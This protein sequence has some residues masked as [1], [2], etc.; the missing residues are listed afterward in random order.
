MHTQ[1]K[2]GMQRRESWFAA[3]REPSR[4]MPDGNTVGRCRKIARA[5]MKS[6]MDTGKRQFV[7]PDWWKAKDSALT[8][9]RPVGQ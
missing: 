9:T 7:E 5:E 4:G 8:S 3:E 1:K 2:V 6:I